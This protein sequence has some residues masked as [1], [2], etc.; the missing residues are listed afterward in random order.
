MQT[1]HDRPSP[2]TILE[3]ALKP[4]SDPPA[5]SL[6]PFALTLNT[7]IHNLTAFAEYY[8]NATMGIERAT[9][10]FEKQFLDVARQGNTS[11]Q[12]GNFRNVCGIDRA[13][14]YCLAHY[15]AELT[16]TTANRVL[17]DLIRRFALTRDEAAGLFLADAMDRLESEVAV[18]PA[19]NAEKKTKGKNIDARM[20]KVLADNKES[21]GWS[22]AQ[23]ADHLK[24]AESTVKDT[25]TWKGPLAAFRANAK[26]DR[27]T[28]ASHKKLIRRNR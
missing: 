5:E 9:D 2:F 27:A 3:P 16:I 21:F 7:V 14:G 6:E 1:M 17:G 10:P 22:A 15:G 23:W 19:T 20:L 25:P 28:R 18:P 26:A 13:R 12:L 24:C 8:E 4:S 11:E